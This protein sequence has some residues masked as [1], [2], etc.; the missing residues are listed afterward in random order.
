LT[1]Y[2][3]KVVGT[4]DFVGLFEGDDVVVGRNDGEGDG[5]LVSVGGA[6][7]ARENVGIID[8]R[9]VGPSESEGR[10]LDDGIADCEG[11][12]VGK[13]VGIHEAEGRKLVLGKGVVV[14]LAEGAG[15]GIG[16]SVGKKDGTSLG[17]GSEGIDETLGDA[18]NGS[19][20]PLGAWGWLLVGGGVDTRFELQH[21]SPSYPKPAL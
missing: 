11:A 20:E 1:K 2:Q 16:D 15:V 19:C 10:L 3:S 8:G 9:L 6:D 12:C 5:L 17:N 21:T 13:L 7:G 4:L 14:G 18:V